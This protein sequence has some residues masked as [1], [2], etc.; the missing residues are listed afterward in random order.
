MQRTFLSK[1]RLTDIVNY[2]LLHTE[3]CT[4]HLDSLN[5]LSW[6]WQHSPFSSINW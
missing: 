4:T 1:Q 6:Q 5:L 2:K 3:S